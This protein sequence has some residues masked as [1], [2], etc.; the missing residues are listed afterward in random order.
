MDSFSFDTDNFPAARRVR[1]YQ[2]AYAPG[3]EVRAIGPDFRA[4]VTAVRLDDS[5]IYRRLINDA[6][7]ERSARTIEKDGFDHF[8]IYAIID[9]AFEVT[10][11]GQ[12]QIVAPESLAVVDLRHPIT[13]RA[14]NALVITLAV[15]RRRL[16]RSTRASVGAAGLVIEGT[17]A[18]FLTR[19]LARLATSA[20]NLNPVEA[21][22]VVNATLGMLDVSIDGRASSLQDA[23]SATRV[24]ENLIEASLE[25]ADLGVDWLVEQTGWS[26]ATIYRQFRHH[27]GLSGYIRDRRL[28]RLAIQ[29]LKSEHSLEELTAQV[30][31]ASS[32]HA[33]HS[34]QRKYGIR[35]GRYRQMIKAPWTTEGTPEALMGVFLQEVV[36]T[37]P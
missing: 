9:G 24:L 16:P 13:T 2:D 14:Q 7:H 26:R 10:M 30:G 19:H 27:G 1:H 20:S 11:G 18:A 3:T 8:V 12:A 31:F 4:S 36:S 32:A 15:A 17:M 35:P 25:N 21:K 33:S 28:R 34:F 37:Q 22:E 29:L 6:E 5:L 23:H